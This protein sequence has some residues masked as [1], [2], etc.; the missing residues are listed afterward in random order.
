MLKVVLVDDER[1][2]L[3]EL[4]FLLREYREISVIAT[5]TNPLEAIEK[6]EHLKPQVVFLDIN[7]PQLRGVDAAS[8]ILDSSADTDIIFITA[9][10][11]YAI[12]AFELHALDYV[13]KPVSKERFKK[14]IQRII[15]KRRNVVP[16][17][18]K[19][20]FKIQTF[21]RFQAGWDGQEPI[22]WRSEKTK[23][24]FA[25]LIHNEGR[26]VTKEEILE[27]IW[28]GTDIEKAV[29]QLH[30]GIYYIRK[31][32]HE[33][34]VDSKQ[35]TVEGNYLLKLGDV[36]VDSLLFKQNIQQSNT[37]DKNFENIQSLE[38][39]YAADYF[40]GTDWVWAEAE[41]EKLCKQYIDV[42]IWLA[43]IYILNKNFN[44]AEELLLNIFKKNPYVEDISKLLIRLYN[45]TN[46]RN[47]SIKHYLEY[48]RILKK[49]LGI[50]PGEDI[51]R[52]IK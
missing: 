4:E 9:Y 46:K 26:E 50:V 3:R 24:L 36:E 48:E 20:K 42:V 29:H 19:K 39:L 49:E 2:A 23:E 18:T 41:R 21:G 44:K 37:G 25:F 40:E 15:N 8:R 11:Q 7:M 16:Q 12:E 38:V 13:L 33:Y 31:T 43:E 35:I 1:P 32:L 30:N 47:R 34:G 52:L 51:R 14:T 45:L 22:K 6:I 28:S 17:E 27:A 5:F 10:E